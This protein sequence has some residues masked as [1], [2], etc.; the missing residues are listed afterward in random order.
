MILKSMIV[1]PVGTNCYLIG[2]ETAGVCAL[3]D[4][5]D[6]AQDLLAMAADTGLTLSA[7]FLTHG[8]YDHR[9]AVPD[10]LKTCPDLPVHIH[11][12][13]RYQESLPSRYFYNGPCVT[14]G[15]GDAVSVGSLSFKVL[16]TPG[17]TAGSVCLLSD[18]LLF[19][20][21]T[22]FAGS[23][24][25][26]DLPGGSM[27]DMFHSLRRLSEI[28]G[29]RQVFSGHGPSTTLAA[30]RKTNPYMRRAMTL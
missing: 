10:I 28:P 26:C 16:E 23:C 1:G 6:Q 11:Y 2:D 21:D 14:Y 8:H 5:G 17:H 30:E 15:E 22:L 19:A 13:E 27:E 3:V 20:G 25:R 4:P 18:D 29:D 24:G 9:D 12:K 7:I